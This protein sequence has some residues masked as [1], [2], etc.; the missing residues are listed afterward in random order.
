MYKW[1]LV[2]TGLGIKLNQFSIVSFYTS[3][4]WSALLKVVLAVVFSV[5]GAGV[6]LLPHPNL[7]IK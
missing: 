7:I 6:T 5:V 1:K 2:L 4:F 3:G